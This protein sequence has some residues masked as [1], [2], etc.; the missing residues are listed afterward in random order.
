MK[1]KKEKKKE[2]VSF[3]R[4]RLT[5]LLSNAIFT[6]QAFST[7]SWLFIALTLITASLMIA[8]I[9]IM[10]NET[11]FLQI[12]MS[13]IVE[14]FMRVWG[15]YCQQGVSGNFYYK[16]RLSIFRFLFCC[17][18]SSL[19]KSFETQMTFWVNY[20]FQEPLTPFDLKAFLWR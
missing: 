19:N 17:L 13:Y 2:E 5:H 15:I 18:F 7:S 11:T 3:N 1:K 16:F 14:N 12:S 4:K 8:F 6:A 9:R 10:V 20:F